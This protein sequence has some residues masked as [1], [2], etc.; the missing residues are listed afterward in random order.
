VSTKPA[1]PSPPKPPAA[2]RAVPAPRTEPANEKSR[3]LPP[4]F[5]A[6][7]VFKFVKAAAFTVFGIAIL[8]LARFAREGLPLEAAG[9][10]G[11]SRD[12]ELVQSAASLLLSITPRQVTALGVAAF[13]LAGVFAAE[14]SFLLARK[15]WSTYFTI[16][17]TMLGIPI[18]LFEIASNAAD[19]KHWGLL[20]VNLAILLFLWKRRNEFRLDGGDS[21]FE[22]C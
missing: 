3:A 11:V 20:A 1:E 8:R 22:D 10:L 4:G 19:W 18:E 16:G 12:N 7:I 5:L 13:S 21:L 14:A 9:V 6:V 17:L 2:G 15:W